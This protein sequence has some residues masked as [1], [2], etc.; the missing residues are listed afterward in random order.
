MNANI[1]ASQAKNT[2]TIL[3]ALDVEVKNEPSPTNNVDFEKDD[4]ELNAYNELL[5]KAVTDPKNASYYLNSANAIRSLAKKKNSVV[6]ARQ[7]A[8]SARASGKSF[9][10]YGRMGGRPRKDE[11]EDENDNHDENDTEGLDVNLSNYKD[12]GIE[13]FEGVKKAFNIPDKVYG[14]DIGR[15]ISS[16]LG[17]DETKKYFEKNP[18]SLKVLN[19]LYKG[20]KGQVLTEESKQQ[21]AADNEPVNLSIG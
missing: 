15:A 8:M 13:L 10:E 20:L 9:S 4:P 7:R 17:S 12:K 21:A 16:G 14:F 1:I 5:N 19:N 6:A 11:E 2:Q 3:N 18:D